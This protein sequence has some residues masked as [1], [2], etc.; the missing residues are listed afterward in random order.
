MIRRA[1]SILRLC[2]PLVALA[3]S[4]PDTVPHRRARIART[5]AVLAS[6]LHAKAAHVL[7]WRAAPAAA[8]AGPGPRIAPARLRKCFADICATVH[9]VLAVV[10][11]Q[12]R[13][14]AKLSNRTRST[15]ASI[16]QLQCGTQPAVSSSVAPA[17]DLQALPSGDALS[18]EDVWKRLLLLDPARVPAWHEL[19]R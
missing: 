7:A 14:Y 18:P 9:S 1:L 17:S 19:L 8:G 5:L 10:D 13:D 15:L 4:Q 12:M 16:F 6:V 2:L 3:L 11:S